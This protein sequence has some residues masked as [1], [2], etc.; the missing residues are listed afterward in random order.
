MHG[1]KFHHS[2]ALRRLLLRAHLRL[3]RARF[4]RGVWFSSSIVPRAGIFEFTLAPVLRIVAAALP[5]LFVLRVIAH[6]QATHEQLWTGALLSVGIICSNP[7]TLAAER[8]ADKGSA[9]YIALIVNDAVYTAAS[10]L[11]LLLSAHSY[12]ILDNNALHSRSLYAKKLAV[13]FLY[14]LVKLITGFGAHVVLGLVPFARILAWFI[15][16]RSGRF[17]ARVAVPVL[18]TTALDTLLTLWLLREV[19]LTARFLARTPYLEHRAKQLGFR[20]F[21]Y[22]SMVFC[23]SIVFLATVAILRLPREILFRNFDDADANAFLQLETPA[24]HLGLAFVYLTWTIVLAY[25]NLPP[26]P[27]LPYTGRA[28]SR[29]F[30]TL[31]SSAPVAWVRARG[32]PLPLPLHVEMT[33]LWMQR[34]HPR[35]ILTPLRNR[36]WSLMILFHCVI[37]TESGL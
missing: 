25:V 1:G 14:F 19:A 32:V 20:C 9:P 16:V 18:L 23:V 24:G 21:V 37:D 13:V 30:Q 22:Q 28:V 34:I 12:R 10:Y 15:L 36:H 7:L 6:G 5:V 27:I 17:S 26:G 3:L 8:S 35:L 33:S 11:Y 29:F 4:V 2:I 31:A